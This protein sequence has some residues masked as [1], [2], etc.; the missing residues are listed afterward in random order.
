[1]VSEA[2]AIQPSVSRSTVPATVAGTTTIQDGVVA[3]IA[4]LAAREVEGV[5]SLGQSGLRATLSGITERVTGESSDR[6]VNVV[7]GT[8]EVAY[9]L[10]V[11]IVY[12]YCI[13][14]VCDNLRR[15]IAERTMEM[16]R[17]STK[18]INVEVVDL[19]FP[20]STQPDTRVE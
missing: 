10:T 4:G 17:L 14:D 11:T 20:S 19:H 13:P 8:K 15:R 2:P 12:G 16:T 9:D 7:V 6:G 3:S 18:E 1:M 5:H